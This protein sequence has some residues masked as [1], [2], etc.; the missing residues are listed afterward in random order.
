MKKILILDLNASTRALLALELSDAGYEVVGARNASHLLELAGKSR[1]DLLVMDVQP[2]R[3]SGLDLLTRIRFNHYDL[4]VVVWTTSLGFKR[5]PRSQAANY[6]VLKSSNPTELL[7][8]VDRALESRVIPARAVGITGFNANRASTQR[9][10]TAPLGLI[11]LILQYPLPR[12]HISG[13]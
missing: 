11:R 8:Y 4:P 9:R 6:Y 12:R 10:R 7:F 1:P 13:C 2:N 5:D 3:H